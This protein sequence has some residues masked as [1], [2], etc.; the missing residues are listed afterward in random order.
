M[1]TIQPTVENVAYRVLGELFA[2][3]GG[4][5]IG[6]AYWSQEDCVAYGESPDDEEFIID[7][8][9][10]RLI[11]RPNQVKYVTAKSC[12]KADNWLSFKKHIEWLEAL[13]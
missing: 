6:Y 2:K 8:S 3:H 4:D 12:R 9:E 13:S 1:K 11:I 7:F 5:D 10:N